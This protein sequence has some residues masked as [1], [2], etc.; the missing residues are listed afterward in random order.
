MPLVDNDKG[1]VLILLTQDC[2]TLREK[3]KLTVT[4]AERNI[5]NGN[6]LRGDKLA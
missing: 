4:N 5:V 1:S 2:Y 3:D 6:V